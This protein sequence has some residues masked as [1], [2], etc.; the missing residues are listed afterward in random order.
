VLELAKNF[1]WLDLGYIL[2]VVFIIYRL[3][4]LRKATRA[5]QMMAGLAVL[6]TALLA[7]HWLGLFTPDGFV[8]NFWSQFLLAV[9]VLFQPEIRRALA[10]IGQILFNYNLT[11][12]EESQTIEETIRAIVSLAAKKSGAIIVLEREIELKDI[13]EMGVPLDAKV[14]KE[15]LISIFLPASP[16]HDGAVII[17]GNRVIAAGCFLPLTLGPDISKVLGTRHRAALGVTQET[18][19]VV[20][21]LSEETGTLSVIIGGKMTRELDAAALRRVL[22]RIFLKEKRREERAVLKKIREHFLIRLK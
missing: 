9:L 5:L 21:V 4:F 17:K 10:R 18:D 16:L 19:A 8:T 6:V 14:S 3:F 2:L 13:V 7:A 12:F 1:R 11:S 22:T 15:L 20:I